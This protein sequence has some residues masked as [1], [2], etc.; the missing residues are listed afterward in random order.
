MNK[1]RYRV[2]KKPI[3]VK[4]GVILTE[5]E[6]V[7]CLDIHAQSSCMAYTY[8]YVIHVHVRTAGSAE[9]ARFRVM[10]IGNA[11]LIARGRGWVR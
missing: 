8:T 4:V 6:L 11:V 7:V 5:N 1:Y 9:L 10:G 2:S 3:G